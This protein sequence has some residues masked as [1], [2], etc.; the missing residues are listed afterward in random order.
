MAL[1]GNLKY[2]LI[3]DEE[4]LECELA[5]LCASSH[6]VSR[7]VSALNSGLLAAFIE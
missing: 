5:K 1:N 2:N 6:A 3:L 4:V 7:G